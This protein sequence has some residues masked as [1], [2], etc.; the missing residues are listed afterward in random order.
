MD[1]QE[2]KPDYEEVHRRLVRSMLLRTWTALPA[3]V[4]EV[5]L[6]EN[7][8]TACPSIIGSAPMED[9]T[10]IDFPI[11]PISDIPLVFP[12]GGG[13][14]LEF[15]VAKDD[16][17]LLVFAS[18]SIDNW[19]GLGGYQPQ[20]ERGRIHNLSDA[21]A[22]PGPRSLPRAKVLD[23]NVVRIRNDANDSY[24]EFNP[25]AKTV[26]IV[27]PGGITLNGVTIDNTGVVTTSAD[28]VAAG[29][30]L[31]THVHSGVQAGGSNTGQPV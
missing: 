29:K 1:R 17:V 15:P 14:F 18:R 19:F 5:N 2:R 8:I 6:T 22:I 9:G 20:S 24:I 4:L 16:E 28:V 21:F 12:G 31:K 10:E 3:I 11:P 26:N 23:V 25:T 27:A 13:A 30:H 7:T